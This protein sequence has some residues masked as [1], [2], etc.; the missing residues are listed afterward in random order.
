[1][2]ASKESGDGSRMGMKKALLGL[3]D[4]VPAPVDLHKLGELG[5]YDEK[6]KIKKSQS[7]RIEENEE[8]MS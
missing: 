5:L 1:M 6:N 3:G 4:A 8:Q 2:C 7:R